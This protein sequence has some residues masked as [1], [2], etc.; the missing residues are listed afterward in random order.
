[1]SDVTPTPA[2]S[3]QDE[4]EEQRQMDLKA[5][6]KIVGAN[7]TAPDRA[8]MTAASRALKVGEALVAIKDGRLHRLTHE[9]WATYLKDRWGFTK[10]RAHQLTVLVE[11]H[12]NLSGQVHTRVDLAGLT[13]R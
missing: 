12:R 1:M 9:T 11:V 3:K 8:E 5:Y 4:R 2:L 13:D 10:Q 7:L 6:E